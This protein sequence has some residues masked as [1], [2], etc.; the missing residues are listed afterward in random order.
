MGLRIMEP[1][2][3]NHSKHQYFHHSAIHMILGIRW[4]QVQEERIT[5]KEVRARFGNISEI[6]DF[7]MRRTWKYIGK[8]V[9]SSQE[10]VPNNLLGTLI[11]C[12]RKIRRPQTSRKNYIVQT[13]QAVLL[14]DVDDRGIF[15]QWIGLARNKKP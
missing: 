14:P 6:D 4:K 2:G 10:T 15:N 9:R 11:Y 1:N 8:T 13:L 5:N 7:I 3:K 12:P